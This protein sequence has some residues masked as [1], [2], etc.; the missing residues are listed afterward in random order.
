MTAPGSPEEIPR[1]HLVTDDEV[2]AGLVDGGAP[3]PALEAVCRAGG[4]RIA[5]HLRAPG[6]D[7][8]R[9]L[10]A[11]LVAAKPA[12]AHGVRLVVNDRVDVAL[13]LRAAPGV[14]V[15]GVQLGRRSLPPG[16]VRVLLDDARGRELAGPDGLARSLLIGQSVGRG[17][18]DDLDPARAADPAA[19]FLVVGTLWPTASH[20]GR[21]GTGPRAVGRGFGPQAPPRIGIGG[22]DPSRVAPVLTAGGHGVAVLRGVWAEVDPAAAVTR[23]LQALDEALGQAP[24]PAKDP[25]QDPAP[26]PAQD[27]SPES[28]SEPDPG[29]PDEHGGSP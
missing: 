28:G 1:L 12:G 26:D 25:V 15:F 18:D 20:P 23:F 29:T 14:E 19:D 5:L 13:A 11:G 17:G 24:D 4:S 10:R 27:P 8:G 7:G 16:E 6:W 21:R 9:L 2:L 3:S 22:I